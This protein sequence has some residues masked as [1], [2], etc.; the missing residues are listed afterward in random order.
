MATRT[1]RGIAIAALVGAPFAVHLA[2]SDPV[3]RPPTP[4]ERRLQPRLLDR[5]FLLRADVK[6][7]RV[8]TRA[9]ISNTYP[10]RRPE[11]RSKSITTVTPDGVFYASDYPDKGQFVAEVR[12]GVQV[13]SQDKPGL[14]IE[15]GGNPTTGDILEVERESEVALRAGDLARVTGVEERTDGIRL[16]I[17]GLAGES[18]EVMLR[19]APGGAE[20]AE[21]RERAVLAIL[22]HLVHLVPDSPADRRALIDPAWA[23]SQQEAVRLGKV[24]AGMS[25]LQVLLAWGAPLHVSR[26]AGGRVDTWLYRPGH[27]VSEQMRRRVDVYFAAGVVTE[28]VE[29][30]R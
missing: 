10:P 24:I 25:P 20:G 22:G 8:E 30:T 11:T 1:V 5:Y 4:L 26:D 16:S 13:N 3:G 15:P 21:E 7:Q 9:V 2:A 27:T 14:K 18:A 23:P 6:I 17:E 29:S 19:E 12:H 28:V